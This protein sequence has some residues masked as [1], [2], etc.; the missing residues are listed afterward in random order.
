MK[1]GVALV[2]VAGVVL[3]IVAPRLF[4]GRPEPPAPGAPTAAPVPPKT[5]TPSAPAQPSAPARVTQ[6]KPAAQPAQPSQARE[7]V[8]IRTVFAEGQE[9]QTNKKPENPAGQQRLA[10]LLKQADT[11]RRQ[12]KKYEA[13]NAFSEAYMLA[14]NPQLRDQI[15]VQLDGL[16]KVLIFSRAPSPDAVVYRVKP[17]DTL[18][19]IAKRHGVTYQLIKR[20]NRKSRDIIVPKERLKI[21]KGEVSALVDKSDFRLVLLLNGRY[22]KEYPI[23]VGR[24]GSETPVGTFEVGTRLVSPTWYAPDGGIYEFG[25]AKNILGT[26]WIGFRETEAHSGYGI[27]GT[28]EPSTVPGR[29]SRGC[30]RMLNRDVEELYDFI[31]AG[32]RV[33]IRD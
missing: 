32:T 8:S 13:R 19:G 28:T 29:A 26:R 3:Y 4:R 22:V 18:G 11:L 20:L 2:I 31:R 21:P 5:Q 25:H 6:A 24:D 17:G 16:N 33:V 10:E 1:K 27:H 23:A 14:T 7:P 15:R 9:R 30:V 12:N